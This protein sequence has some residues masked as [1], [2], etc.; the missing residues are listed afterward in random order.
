MGYGLQLRLSGNITKIVLYSDK[1]VFENTLRHWELFTRTFWSPVP[2]KYF[3]KVYHIFFCVTQ[4]TDVCITSGKRGMGKP[5]YQPCFLHIFIILELLWHK[6]E[7]KKVKIVKYFWIFF[8]YFVSLW[9]LPVQKKKIDTNY[10]L[11]Q[12]K[13]N[14]SWTHFMKY[15]GISISK[16]LFLKSS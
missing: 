6:S 10:W 8:F 3:P 1:N 11:N 13:N 15:S 5:N 12:S 14:I 4:S 7:T 16:L 2:F 9:I